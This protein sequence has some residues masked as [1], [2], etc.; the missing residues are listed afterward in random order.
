MAPKSS[1]PKRKSRGK[2]RVARMSRWRRKTYNVP[3]QASCS[4]V[5]SLALQNTG[6]VYQNYKLDLA[7]HIRA[8][9]IAKGYQYFRIKSV[10][11]TFKPLQDT[12]SGAGTSIPHLYYMIDRTGSLRSVQNADMLKKLGA[13]PRRLDDKLVTLTYRP[14]V[15]NSSSDT[16]PGA[17]IFVQY[18]M[19][20]WLPTR[21]AS[22]LL[23]WNPNTT[24]HFGLVYIVENVGGQTIQYAVERE[25]QFEFKKP[26]YQ[27]VTN[28]VD[29]A[30]EEEVVL[31]P[32]GSI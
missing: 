9:T 30:P 12:F 1:K 13:R 21:E 26:S 6:T 17:D 8:S 22:Q 3:E 29:P 4:E 24:D 28:L 32:G 31:I 23:T 5:Q 19:T 7:G 10:K 16:T 27:V 11:Y 18:K 14:S 20:P 15:L 25:V 2:R